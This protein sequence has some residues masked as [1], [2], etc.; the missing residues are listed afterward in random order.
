VLE[1][2]RK[3]LSWLGDQAKAAYAYVV[4]CYPAAAAYVAVKAEAMVRKV[5]EVAMTGHRLAFA[6][7][8]R[9]QAI[10]ILTAA[11]R[12]EDEQ[13][14]FGQAFGRARA[15]VKDW[16]DMDVANFIAH[17]YAEAVKPQTVELPLPA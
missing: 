14:S 10:A 4:G 17:F 12:R 7:F 8:N 5:Y 15:E 6:A 3:G 11:Y 16:T 13:A 2:I 9:G 1:S